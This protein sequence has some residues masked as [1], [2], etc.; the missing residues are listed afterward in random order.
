MMGC[1]R[2]HGDGAPVQ[3]EYY[4][5]MNVAFKP[6]TTLLPEYQRLSDRIHK[7]KHLARFNRMPPPDAI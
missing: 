3:E 7:D 4:S 6:D 1:G 5:G 2:D